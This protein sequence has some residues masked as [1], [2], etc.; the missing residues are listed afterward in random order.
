[1]NN[2]TVSD[3]MVLFD[4]YR[5]K[6]HSLVS[7][8]VRYAEE[9]QEDAD[10]SGYSAKIIDELRYSQKILA[11]NIM[12]TSLFSAF[13][14][15]KSTTTVAMADGHE[16]T[17]C[18]KGGG[19]IRLSAVPLTIYHDRHATQVT[20][21]TYSKEKLVRR[22]M[23]VAGEHLDAQ[24]FEYDLDN[25]EHR[26]F[27]KAAICKEIALFQQLNPKEDTYDID[28][29][30]MLRSAILTIALYGS[31][32]HKNLCAG[33][34]KSIDDIQ[35][36]ISFSTEL[37]KKWENLRRMGFDVVYAK[38]EQGTSLFV[39][40][41]HLYVF[42][43]SIIVP[44]HSEFMEETGTAVI[45]APGT[46]ASIEDTERALKAANEA[47]VVLYI[48]DGESQLSQSD[49]N[50]LKVLRN[51]GMA[52]KVVFVINFRKNPLIIQQ[53]GGIGEAILAGIQQQGYTMPHHSYLLYYNAF[54]AVR[55]AQGK[56]LMEGKLDKLSEDAIMEDARKR[57]LK[58]ETVM[59]AWKKT[60]SRV[61]RA[62]DADDAADNLAQNGLCKET[63]AEIL[64]VS[65][66]REMIDKLR[67]HVMNNR[68]AGILRD[69]GARPVIGALKGIENSLSNTE[70]A[71]SNNLEDAR[72]RYAEARKMLDQ[73]ALKTD[74]LL[75]RYLPESTDEEIA[76]DYF[77]HVILGA[78]DIAATEAAPE[79]FK[80]SGVVGQVRNVGDKIKTGFVRLGE[81]IKDTWDGVPLS[82][83]W[84]KKKKAPD[85][86][87]ERCQ[88]IIKKHLQKAMVQTASSWAGRLEKTSVYQRNVCDKVRDIRDAMKQLWKD[89]GLE[90]EEKLSNIKPVP[91]GLTGKMSVDIVNSEIRTI[92]VNTTLSANLTVAAMLK[93]VSAGM[94]AA[95]GLTYLYY[96]VLPLDF[97]IPGFA[98]LLLIVSAA[99]AAIVYA[100]RKKKKE[101]HISKLAD[102][103]SKE[104]Y[105]N[106]QK[107]KHDI[108][109]MIAT[110]V[111]EYGNHLNKDDEPGISSIRLFY[112]SLFKSILEMQRNDL[113]TNEQN[114]LALLKMSD[115]QR[116]EVVEKAKTW[117]VKKIEPLR[118][119]LDRTLEEINQIWS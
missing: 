20:V 36:F 51:A 73:F 3:E 32:E 75:D 29:M 59:D 64:E 119:E 78:V 8:S 94:G 4:K 102:D 117:R 16:I 67:A 111:D 110:G 107:K 81:R 118:K 38:D 62:V 91:D 68:V 43:E 25:E 108:V 14:K 58:C 26:R 99:V 33:A 19:G 72:K 85:W 47:A 113:S 53:A 31:P 114:E 49:T 37:E 96:F 34:Y 15:G 93:S 55:A 74:R 101:K 80:E 115:K 61:L 39:P 24:D 106:F 104:L 12:P 45:D 60:T 23:E 112:V 88:G 84:K 5:V 52:E 42:V 1:M 2:V 13:Q 54:L 103:I 97:I 116:K 66:W 48:L 28:K 76:K 44:V 6:L 89:L 69:L 11:D 57:L 95:V 100:V 10:F 40:K 30:N 86:L 63:V 50:M 90:H 77:D 35:S 17:P 105:A 27:L 79:V 7:D 98:E 41:E 65:Q 71:M 109:R 22:I 56:L 21:N 18:G 9:L 83:A 82:I 87:Q 92:L 46:M 70:K